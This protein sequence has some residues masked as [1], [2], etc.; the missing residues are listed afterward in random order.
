MNSLYLWM[1]Y[2][3][4]LAGFLFLMG[5]GVAVYMS[6]RLKQEK[7]VERIKSLLDLSAA[8]FPTTMLALLALL[9]AGII[10]GFMGQWWGTG[11]IWASL[12]ILIGQSVWMNSVSKTYHG[13]RKLL[14]MPYMEGNKPREAMAPQPAETVLAH[15]SKT[16]PKELLYIGIGGFAIIL[17]LMMF[18]PF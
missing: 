12:V 15:L 16:R 8:A 13:A 11:W 1:K 3:H 5:H 18:K 4:A 17:W 9:I 2:I 10:T 14:G 7:D 6:F